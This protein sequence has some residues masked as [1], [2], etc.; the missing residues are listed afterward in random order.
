MRRQHSDIR[1]NYTL[2]PSF[3]NVPLKGHIRKFD[4]RYMP[5]Q[6]DVYYMYTCAYDVTPL[7]CMQCTY[8]TCDPYIR[9]QFGLIM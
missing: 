3:F 2:N 1:W 6:P 5:I 9:I 4:C 8:P 7:K